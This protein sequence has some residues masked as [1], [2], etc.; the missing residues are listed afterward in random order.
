M[1]GTRTSVTAGPAHVGQDAGQVG[2][3]A[4]GERAVDD[5]VVVGERQRQHQPRLELRPVPD[6]L[7]RRARRAEDRDLRPV[8]DRREER[9]ADPA[10]A[11][12]RERRVLHVGQLELALAGG[13]GQPREFA[14]DLEDPLAVGVLDD[15]DDEALGRVGGEADVPVAL[16]QQ[17][18]PVLVERAVDLG[19]LL[20]RGHARLHQQRDHRDLDVLL[21]GVDLLA[22]RLERRDVRLVVL[23]DVRDR[24]PA[25]DEVRPGDLLD[26]RQLHPLDALAGRD[27]RGLGSLRGAP[28]VLLRD[29]ALAAR[30][31]DGGE[32]DA[33]LACEPAHRGARVGRCIGRRGAGRLGGRRVRLGRR[34]G[35]RRGVDRARRRCLRRGGGAGR[36]RRGLR[37]VPGRLERQQQRA[38]RHLVAHR[39]LQLLHDAAERRRHVHRRLVGLERDQRVLRRDRV[40]GRHQHLDHRYV[41]EVAD[42]RDFHLRHGASASASISYLAIASAAFSGATER[43]AASAT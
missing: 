26:P 10:E 22:E 32:I 16:E 25:A 40:A 31:L 27:R 43:S 4:R 36:R 39:D 1:S 29:A 9:P 42:V 33:S 23:G 30:P 3:E 8:D 21:G 2:R 28:H 13:A 18:L 6:G 38:L 17:V 7:H 35:L 20:Q 15:G 11:G 19:V 41:G 37:A 12:D 24:R 14:G 5:P 34:L